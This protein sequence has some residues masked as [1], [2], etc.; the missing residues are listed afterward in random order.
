MPAAKKRSSR[1]LPQALAN[2]IVRHD[3]VPPDQLL[4]NPLNFRRHPGEQLDVLRG[5]LEQLGWLKTVI[6][7]ETTGHVLDGHARVEEALH[8]QEK[9][10]PVTIVALSLEE[11]RLALAILDPSSEMAR[12]DDAIL[13]DLLAEVQTTDARLALFL[14]ELK[15]D[16]HPVLEAGATA[17]DPPSVPRTKLGD[18]WELGPH[19]LVCGD[20]RDPAAWRL[21][22]QGGRAHALWTDPPYNV[23][24]LGQALNPRAAIENDKL[25]PAAFREMLATVLD[26]ALSYLL[27][28]SACY[29]AAPSGPQFLDFALVLRP[30]GIWRQTLTWVKNHH[31]MG[32]SDYHYKHE[33][34]FEGNVPLAPFEPEDVDLVSYGWKPGGPHEWVGGRSRSTVFEV[35]KPPA[36]AAHPTMKPP[37]LIR[38]MLEASTRPTE[39]VVDCFAGSGSTLIAC[40]EINR[41]AR[42]LELDPGYCD[43][44]AQRFE[45]ATGMEAKLLT[46]K[47]EDG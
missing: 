20:A 6:V 4:A 43:A 38:A 29:I 30:R 17:P 28:G 37:E 10:V 7:N 42:L 13:A 3:D 35:A 19:R 23:E 8:R 26:L 44:I 1:P 2:R 33:V 36:S 41:I 24:Y 22:M 18:V 11:E 31:V 16:L 9:T 14:D 5:S 15:G 45:E 39:V 25:S 40:E 12:T 34:L 27:A 47:E 32:R 21:L 46:P